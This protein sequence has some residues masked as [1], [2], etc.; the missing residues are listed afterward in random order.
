MISRAQ[1]SR[2]RIEDEPAEPDRGGRR[3]ACHEGLLSNCFQ[4]ISHDFRSK[5]PRFH[6]TRTSWVLMLVKIS[7]G[8]GGTYDTAGTASTH[9]VECGFCDSLLRATPPD[10]R[11]LRSSGRLA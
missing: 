5:A 6:D 2:R 7:K 1:R 11:R 9:T 4:E 10:V 3:Q 8:T